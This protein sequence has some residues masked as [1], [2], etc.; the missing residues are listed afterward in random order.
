MTEIVDLEAGTVFVGGGGANHAE[1][2]QLLLKYANRH[3][4]IAGA[5]GTGKTVTL[6]TLAESFSRAGVPVF[7]ADVKGDLAGIAKPGRAEGK[8]HESFQKRAEQI[9]VE[10]DYQE[11]PVTFWDIW[12]KRGHPVRTTPAEMGP[13]LLSRLMGLTDAQEGVMNIAFRVADEEG[14]ALLDM[15]DLQAMLVWVGQ[16]AKELSLKYGNVSTASV[17]A[18]QRALMVLQNEGGDLLFGEPALELADL[19][20]PDASGKGMINILS[21]ERLMNAPRLYATFLLW[22][23]SELFEQLPEVG[24]PD[25]P[26]IAFFF[27][28]AHLLFDDAPPALIDKI[29]QVA[30]L[31]R[32]KGVSLWFISQNPA[33]LPES[34]L[35]QLGNRV[36]HALRAFTAKDQKA[37]RLAAQNYR[38][39]PEFDTAEAIQ[40][41]GTGEAVTSFLEAK[42]VPGIVQRTL[43]RPPL[44]QLGPIEDAERAA[45]NTQSPMA[46]KYGKSLDRESAAELLAKRAEAAAVD[47]AGA[48]A[49]AGAG[50]SDDD[51]LWQ[52]GREHNR[53]R[54]Y[55]PGLQIPDKPRPRASSGSRS[56]S[57]SI[58][59]TFGKSLARQ[60]GTKTGQA[61]VRGVLGSLF[62]G[63]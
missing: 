13:L 2:Q 22:L 54:R 28:E 62:R 14:L 51:D 9:G 60:L 5:T 8:L 37:L 35:G 23:M 26:R 53:G 3:G 6:Q 41:V 25:K 38:P 39:N 29:E 30:R 59:V 27:D 40:S 63:K 24:D 55:N 57:D 42:G 16:N 43:I 36:Q 15:K 49:T 46:L 21:A 61:L 56:N 34:V 10:L 52:M 20:R 11:F 48:G 33:D 32:S 17:G 44:S 50:R 7:L 47:S 18:I 1:P 12:G 19:M 31:I 4:L 45:I 58:A